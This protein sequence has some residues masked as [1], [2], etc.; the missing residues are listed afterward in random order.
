MSQFFAVNMCVVYGLYYVE[1]VSLYAHFLESFHHTWVLNF[2]KSFSAFVEMI[3]WFLFFNLAIWPIT[4]IDFY[5][6]KN[7]CIPG[8]SPT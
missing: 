8:F 6:L 2:V 5:R 1:V 3:V 7:P 4:L